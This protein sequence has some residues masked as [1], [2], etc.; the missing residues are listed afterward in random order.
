MSTFPF[1]MPVV[2]V[3]QKD[4]GP[5]CLFVLGVSASAVH[6]CWKGPD[7]KTLLAAL[8]VAS[9]PE[10]FWSGDRAEAAAIVARVPVPRG[11]G[12]LT[13]AGDH[14]NG[15]SGR[16]L[17]CEYLKPLGVTRADAWLCDLIVPQG[18]GPQGSDLETSF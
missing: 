10:I 4:R 17:D 11:A 3:V 14:L 1:G 12:K 2:P 5:K 13:A 9:E 8:A 15:P 6:A 7:G 16:T 18:R